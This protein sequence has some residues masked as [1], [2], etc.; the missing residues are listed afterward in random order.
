MSIARGLL[1]IVLLRSGGYDYAELDLQSPIHL[2]AGNNVGKTTLIAALQFLYIDDSRQMHFAHEWPKTKQHY[3]PDSGSF[4]LFECMTPTGLQVFGLRGKGPVQGFDYER[5]A[6]SGAYVRSDFLEGRTPLPWTEVSPRLVSRDLRPMEP[7]H[8]RASL[9]GSGDSKGPPLGLVPLKRSGSYDSFRFL[10]RNLLRLSRIEQRQ[11][12][13]LFIDISRPRLR[14]VEVDIRRDYSEMFARVEKDA[15]DVEALQA[16]APAIASLVEAFEARG[17]VRGR[18]VASWRRIEDV[19]E[20]ERL[21][22]RLAVG[23]LETRRGAVADELHRVEG[24]QKFAREEVENLGEQRGR[25]QEKKRGLVELRDRIRNFEPDL[26]AASRRQLQGRVD[27]L[28]ARLAGANRSSRPQVEGELRS[29]RQRLSADKQLLARYSDAVVTWLRSESGLDDNAL[30]NVFTVVNPALL[31]EVLGGDR[32]QVG[33]AQAAVALVAAI[34]SAFD[35]TGFA[36]HGIHVRPAVEGTPSPLVEYLDVGVVRERVQQ[37]TRRIEELDQVLRDLAEVEHL[38]RQ[39]DDARRALDDA[40]VRLGDWESWTAQQRDLDDAES[41]LADL[42]KQAQEVEARQQRLQAEH[43]Q[44]AIEA[45][46][47]D[48]Q[49][50][51]LQGALRRHVADVQR[52]QAPPIDWGEG[53]LAPGAEATALDELVRGYRSDHSRQQ[54]LDRE[55]SQLFSDVEN[56]TAGRHVAATEAETID[57]L[58]DELS[59]LHARQKAVQELWT[60]LVD[61]MC[62]AFK[63]LIEAVD[64]VQREVSRLTSALNRR[65]VSNLEHVEL[66][67]VKQR[68]LIERLQRVVHVED[69]PLFAGAG[70]RTQA[71]REVQSWL[72]NRPRIHLAELFDLRFSIVDVRG[73]T[74]TFESLSQIESQGT[75]TTIKVLVHLELLRTMLSDESVSLPFFL[76]EVATLDPANL[77][78]LVEHATTMGFVPIIASPE[79]RD[80]VDT[81][82]FL[83]RSAGGLVLDETSRVRLHREPTSGR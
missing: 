83:R 46:G 61:G 51:D 75:S 31:G 11:L 12:K 39:R 10:F 8:L 53:V 33:D 48:N 74:K 73:K 81:L 7:K 69:E 30:A 50:G 3:F 19:L 47:F 9:T 40:K 79:A 62:S 78:A 44:L 59:A 1:R 27:E 5:F 45:S 34:A 67:L 55:A 2:V 56:K 28:V 49:I 66:S 22:V 41:R 4:V 68:D 71:A 25:L 26:E 77:S 23:D 43:T 82:Y 17:Q 15:Q 20:N 21:R 36:A 18:Q 16:V 63:S 65:Q 35:D 54:Q 76:D 24:E 58:Q 52:L 6:Y 29:L 80:A 57:R 42:A 13:E 60:S 70:G 37:Q 32:V 14:Q 64:E 38:E 72:E